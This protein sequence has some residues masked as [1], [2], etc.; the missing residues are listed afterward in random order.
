MKKINMLE[1]FE[2]YKILLHQH[3]LPLPLLQGEINT[4]HLQNVPKRKQLSSHKLTQQLFPVKS[5]QNQKNL[6][7]QTR[8]LH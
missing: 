1:L 7:Q 3:L 6:R 8:N 5:A 2:I 4:H